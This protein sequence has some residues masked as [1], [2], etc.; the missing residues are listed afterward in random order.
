ME[1]FNYEELTKPLVC[2]VAQKVQVGRN[3]NKD[4]YICISKGMSSEQIQHEFD[5]AM[6]DTNDETIITGYTI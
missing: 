6:K 5:K 3:G 4:I 1:A 2:N